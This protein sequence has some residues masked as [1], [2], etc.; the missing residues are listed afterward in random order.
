MQVRLH[1]NATTTP[2]T[3]A[4]IQASDLPMTVLAD[5]LGVW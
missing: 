1:K 5:R 3:R 2:K 4:L